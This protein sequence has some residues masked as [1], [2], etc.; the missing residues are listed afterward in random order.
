MKHSVAGIHKDKILV[1]LTP[2]VA[3]VA[4]SPKIETMAVP[5][6]GRSKIDRDH[7]NFKTEFNPSNIQSSERLTSLA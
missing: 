4:P 6:S 3:P 2:A 1:D 7:V 5:L